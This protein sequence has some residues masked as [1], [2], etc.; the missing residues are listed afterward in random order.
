MCHF[1]SFQTQ[2]QP[3]NGPIWQKWSVW[4]D[5]ERLAQ[6]FQMRERFSVIVDNNKR[7]ETCMSG[8][9]EDVVWRILGGAWGGWTELTV[10]PRRQHGCL[11]T[12]TWSSQHL[13][14]ELRPAKANLCGQTSYSFTFG[15]V[16]PHRFASAAVLILGKYCAKCSHYFSQWQHSVTSIDRDMG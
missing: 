6:Q 8:A 2:R 3:Q 12:M 15:Y 7:R 9:K 16:C 4:K 1:V 13:K 10:H 14:G 11:L 5:E